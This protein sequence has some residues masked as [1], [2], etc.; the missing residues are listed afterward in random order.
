MHLQFRWEWE[1]CNIGVVVFGSTHALWYSGI[2]EI[3]GLRYC[4]RKGWCVESSEACF[5]IQTLYS[6][7]VQNATLCMIQFRS[8]FSS[9]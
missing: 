7:C 6:I 4:M 2:E 8:I 3:V 5:S 1:E 9:V